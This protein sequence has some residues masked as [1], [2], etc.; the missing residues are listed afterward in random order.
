M[1]LQMLEPGAGGVLTHVAELTEHLLQRGNSAAVAFSSCRK[2]RGLDGFSSLLKNFNVPTIDMRVTN[3]PSPWDTVALSRIISFCRRNRPRL[4][5][6]HSAKAGV[7]GRCVAKVIGVPVVY[8]PHAYAGLQPR[9]TLMTRLSNLAERALGP[10]GYT[11][12]TNQQEHE[13]ATGRLGITDE[14]VIKIHNGVDFRKYCPAD[15]D[16]KWELRK[17][18][19]LPQDRFVIASICRL[20]YQKD[21]VTLIRGFAAAQ[22]ICPELHLNLV[23]QGSQASEVHAVAEQLG[24]ASAFTWSDYHGRPHEVYKTADAFLSTARYEGLPLVVLEALAS[25]LPLVLTECP[26]HTEFQ[27]CG[28]NKLEY[29]PLESPA[30]VADGLLNLYERR[31]ERTDHRSASRTY[32]SH[33]HALQR[34]ISLYDQLLSQ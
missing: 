21:P 15:E 14:R 3:T 10:V 1:I 7:L 11:V 20:E 9:Q 5:H 25:D 18:Q 4:I 2:D 8:T 33:D 30:H 32:F 34:T 22:R 19:S 6:C 12:A 23:G 24:I 31:D 16:Q 17:Q 28:F 27:E 26:G 13:F 29:V